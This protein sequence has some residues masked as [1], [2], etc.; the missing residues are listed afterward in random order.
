MTDVHAGS[1]HYQGPVTVDGY[2]A[3]AVLSVAHQVI[4]DGNDGSTFGATIWS[5]AVII[6]DSRADRNLLEFG[7]SVEI[8]IGERSA[9]AHIVHAV[10]GS[11]ALYVQAEGDPPFD[12][13]ADA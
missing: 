6:L 13:N 7:R 9:R 5:G 2:N 10:P 11:N 8:A 3:D 1:Y 4:N 12:Q